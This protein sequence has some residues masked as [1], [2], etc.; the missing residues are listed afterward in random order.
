MTLS[1]L[2]HFH[3]PHVSTGGRMLIQDSCSFALFPS[4]ISLYTHR[5][6]R[7]PLCIA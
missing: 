6:E 7:A 1:R 4:Q 2:G 3:C 5:V